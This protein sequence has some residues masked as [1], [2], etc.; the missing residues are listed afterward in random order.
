ML[1][2][3]RTRA[4]F[5][6]RQSF[7]QLMRRLAGKPIRYIVVGGGQLEPYEGV[8]IENLGWRDSLEAIYERATV[9]IRNTPRDGLSL[10]VLEALSYG[11]H[12]LWTQQFPFTREIHSYGDMEREIVAL[13]EAHERGELHPQAQA[14]EMV[15]TRYG[16][17][18]CTK[19]IAQAWS[20]ALKHPVK[21]NL[22]METS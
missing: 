10:M 11:R 7:K 13:Y 22:A 5:Y 21:R 16:V 20:D 1:Y 14:S 19:R 8:E 4:D 15:R 9:L 17:E 3:P 18:A 12:V 2:V 6:G